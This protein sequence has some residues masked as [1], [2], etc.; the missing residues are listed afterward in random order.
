M[1]LIAT[2]LARGIALVAA[3]GCSHVLAQAE[4]NAF[5]ESDSNVLTTGGETVGVLMVSTTE[6]TAGLDN[7]IPAGGVI[8]GNLIIAG[9]APDTAA[10]N[11]RLENLRRVEGLLLIQGSLLASI[12]LPNLEY[13]REVNIIHSSLKVFELTTAMPPQTVRVGNNRSLNTFRI[14]STDNTD[15]SF[16]GA[17]WRFFGAPQANPAVT[18][19]AVTIDVTTPPGSSIE[20]ID[21]SGMENI[22][23]LTFKGVNSVNAL[24]VS[25]LNFATNAAKAIGFGDLTAVT[26]DLSIVA[27]RSD[28]LAALGLSALTDIQ[29]SLT[30]ANNRSLLSLGTLYA[31]KTAGSL[32][33]SGNTELTSLLE[34]RLLERVTG[35]F[36]LLDN[37]NLAFSQGLDVLTMIGG[38]LQISMANSVNSVLL[39]DFDA[40]STLTAVGGSVTLRG[41]SVSTFDGLENIEYGSQLTVDGVTVSD[42]CLALAPLAGWG[43]DTFPS[44]R[45]TLNMLG[46]VPGCNN[47]RDDL[48]AAAAPFAPSKPILT[49]PQDFISGGKRIFV[50]NI[51]SPDGRFPPAEYGAYCG[52]Q[53][54]VDPSVPG[55]VIVSSSIPTGYSSGALQLAATGMTP[56]KTY[57]CRARVSNASGIFTDSDAVQF[58]TPPAITEPPVINSIEE[59]DSGI[60]VSYTRAVVDW[61]FTDHTIVCGDLRVPSRNSPD[62]VALNAETE[63]SCSVEAST[64]GFETVQSNVVTYTPGGQA[65]LSIPMLFIANCKSEPRPGC[66]R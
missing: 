1:N 8:E 41:L 65:S 6:Q 47:S 22:T 25:S 40:F 55:S 61:I 49:F 18:I 24:H 51:S 27:M 33:V 20:Q 64:S 63:H 53:D 7:C 35:N 58:T 12:D 23:S 32:N 43:D 42:N 2:S 60:S 48:L 5:I 38:D 17:T 37:D 11:L 31:L 54:I 57:S 46:G 45:V 10:L 44:A 16:Q 14:V 34:L 13:V 50:D 62:E 56:G 28:S 29:G 59:S 39:P 4:C 26:G 15:G 3:M 66:P 19:P 30:I 52:Y 21:L 36:S 9:V